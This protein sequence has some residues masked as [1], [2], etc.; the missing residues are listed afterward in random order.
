MLNYRNVYAK[1][2]TEKYSLGQNRPEKN[3][4]ITG[5]DLKREN[6]TI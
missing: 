5:L 1:K 3:Q 6:K 2:D 4:K